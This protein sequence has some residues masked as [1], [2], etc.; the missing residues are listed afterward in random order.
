MRQ[1]VMLLNIIR[2]HN[3]P[4]FSPFKENLL[5][6]HRPYLKYSSVTL[7]KDSPFFKG[8]M[9]NAEQGNELVIKNSTMYQQHSLTFN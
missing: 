8:K 6:L 2:P 9:D 7:V 3:F 5:Y 4:I 1:H